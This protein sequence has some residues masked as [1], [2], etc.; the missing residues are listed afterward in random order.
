LRAKHRYEPTDWLGWTEQEDSS[1]VRL[2]NWRDTHRQEHFEPLSYFEEEEWTILG[3]TV[4]NL[5]EE[6]DERVPMLNSEGKHA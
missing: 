2:E 1:A 5:S 6:P 4:E 3:H